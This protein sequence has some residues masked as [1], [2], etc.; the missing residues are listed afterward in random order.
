MATT[1]KS[2]EGALINELVDALKNRFGDPPE[3]GIVLG[4]G[5]GARAKG[6]IGKSE[7]MQL[8]ELPHWPAPSIEGHSPSLVVGDVAGRRIALSGGRTH[9]YEGLPA[10]ELV[11]GVRS[12]VHWGAPSVLL[13]N[14]A[15]S[16]QAGR[17][18]GSL[19]PFLDHINVNLPDPNAANQTADSRPL[20]LN[21]I[22][23][24]DSQWREKICSQCPDL[25]PG[26]YVGLQGPSYET[27]HEVELF[28]GYGGAAVGMSTIPEA[29]AARGAG[30]KVMAISLLTNF[31]AGIEGGNPSHQEVLEAA[32]T[33]AGSAMDVLMAAVQS[34]P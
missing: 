31:A 14:A 1:S 28:R 22:N 20:F 19:M 33:H 6:L 3:I 29:L 21:T 11:R 34:A 8:D 15:G 5:W 30:A 7:E 24:Y 13:L 2:D 32:R 12:L 25:E 18:P 9:A 17:S 16:L 27:P 23:L 10:R 4:S 26:V